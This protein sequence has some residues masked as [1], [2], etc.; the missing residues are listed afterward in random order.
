MTQVLE[1]ILAHLD[2]LLGICTAVYVLG[3]L[4]Y[5]GG[6]KPCRKVSGHQPLVSIVVAARNEAD[7]IRACLDS[8]L[9]QN[10]PVDAYEII[11]VDDGSMDETARIVR[12]KAESSRR[13]QLLSAQEAGREPGSK[14]AALSQGIGAAKGE[15]ILTTD[16]DCRVPQTWVRGMVDCFA[17]EVGM[18]VGF[19]RIENTGMDLRTGWEA[20]DF[21]C[22]MACAAGS[23]GHG[24]PMGGSG[25]NLAYRKAAFLEVGGFE[26]VQ[27]RVSG[28]DVLLLQLIRGLKRWGTAFSTF[29]ETFVVHPASSSWKAL[30]NQR[31]RW[32]SNA[33]CQFHMDPLFFLYMVDVFT[34]N[35]LLILSPLLVLFGMLS[36][37]WAGMCWGAK[38][39]AEFT[40]FHKGTRFFGGS[41]LLRYFPLWTLTQ[42]L[43]I[44]L[45]GSLGTLGL[46]SWKGKAYRWGRSG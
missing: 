16:A 14:K 8:L 1:E 6:M 19:S 15:I 17:D 11:V 13:V 33:P 28:D 3:A 45:V 29:P 36:P 18:V 44:V 30:L 20:L 42:P 32:A 5:A 27:H 35:I 22:L 21:L 12:K 41:N 40:V 25:Q 38:I 46:F 43:Y 7:H 10:Y 9:A 31:S 26:R 23:A 4:W 34:M 24:H 2:V 37:A 39:A